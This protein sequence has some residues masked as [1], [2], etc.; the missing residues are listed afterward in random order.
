MKAVGKVVHAGARS[1]IAESMVV[2]GEGREIAR[3]ESRRIRAISLSRGKRRE[4]SARSVQSEAYPSLTRRGNETGLGTR[5][6]GASWD[7]TEG[8]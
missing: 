1:F 7:P 6:G 2:D 4:K 3:A 5:E 8:A